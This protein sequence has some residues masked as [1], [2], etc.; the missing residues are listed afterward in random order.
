MDN[1][2]TVFTYF[3]RDDSNTKII[4]RAVISG[5][6]T[7]EQIETIRNCANGGLFFLPWQVGLGD[8][9]SEE[10]TPET[11]GPWHELLGDFFPTVD[12][13]NTGMTA[14]DLVKAFREAKGRWDTSC[15][16]GV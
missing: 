7:Q 3:C 16:P 2:N 8:T 5:P 15:V 11:D 14:G 10:F 12:P 6:I 13:C 1:T 9:V 4:S